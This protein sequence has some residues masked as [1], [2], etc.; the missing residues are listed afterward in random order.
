MNEKQAVAY[1]QSEFDLKFETDYYD[2]FLTLV[3]VDYFNA[4]GHS[5]L[6]QHGEGTGEVPTPKCADITVIDCEGNYIDHMQ[7]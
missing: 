2:G 7:W 5:I 3:S 6:I 4:D 1:F